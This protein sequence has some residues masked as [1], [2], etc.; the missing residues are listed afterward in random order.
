MATEKIQVIDTHTAGEPTRV[1]IG[2]FPDLSGETIAECRDSLINDHD[3]LRAGIVR[4]PRGHDAM[5][6]ALLLD[7]SV[8]ECVA[9]V[10]FFNNVGALGMCG[11][12]AIGVVKALH[13]LGRIETGSC[14]LETPAGVIETTLHPDGEISI[15]NVRSYRFAENVSVTLDSGAELIG[16]VAW[17]GNWFFITESL[18]IPIEASRIDDLIDQQS[19]FDRSRTL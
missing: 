7:S 18:G 2:G 4:E 14:K 1:I 11:H 3:G 10:I 12:G 8:E 16:E 6:A 5:V 17:G 13:H 9:G 19:D 15:R